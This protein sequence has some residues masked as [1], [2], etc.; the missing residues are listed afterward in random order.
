MELER[1]TLGKTG[2]IAHEVSTGDCIATE[3][4]HYHGFTFVY[5]NILIGRRNLTLE[6]YRE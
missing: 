1:R 2:L 4:G 3:R 6:E 5:E